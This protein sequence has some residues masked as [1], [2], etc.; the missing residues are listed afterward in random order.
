M[1]LWDRGLG[2]KTVVVRGLRVERQ[3]GES[4]ILR[5]KRQCNKDG[6]RK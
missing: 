6:R 5:T 2:C 3:Q 4:E 1:T